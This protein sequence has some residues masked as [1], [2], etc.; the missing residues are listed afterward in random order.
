MMRYAF[1][2]AA[3][4]AAGCTTP[5]FT[6]PAR[7]YLDIRP[8]AISAE[9]AGKV[10]GI[11][12]LQSARPYEQRVVYRMPDF[13]LGGDESVQWAE[14]P[15]AAVTRALSDALAASGRFKDVGNAAD[16]VLPD[17]TLTG[18]VRKFDE[19]RAVEPWT[20][21]CEVRIELRDAQSGEPL[22]A[23]TLAASVPLER[24]EHAALPAAMSK[25][26]ATVVTQAV[27]EIIAR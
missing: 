21:D 7:Y 27:K 20:A 10:L 25:A 17:W 18:E 11:R 5:S 19:N 2:L 8:D 26:V 23:G 24:N 4:L 15:R 1:L 12:T 6:R 13:T 14:L 9:P 3:L 16:I 22:W